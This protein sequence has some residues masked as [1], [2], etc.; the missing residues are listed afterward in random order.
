[1]PG[2]YDYDELRE[3]ALSADA[4]QQDLENMARW[5]NN[6]DISAWN[7]EYYDMGNGKRLFPICAETEPDE[8][9]ITGYEIK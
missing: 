3:K 2:Y 9:E 4:T 6:Y 5:F 7:G 1:M 8:W